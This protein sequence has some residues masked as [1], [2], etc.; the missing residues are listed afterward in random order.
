LFEQLQF[1]SRED[2]NPLQACDSC[3]QVETRS[4]FRAGRQ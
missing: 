3:P 1:H 2:A 4:A